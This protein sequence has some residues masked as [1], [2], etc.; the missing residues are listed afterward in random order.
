MKTK[1]TPGPWI[2]GTFPTGASDVRSAD[3]EICLCKSDFEDNQAN[4]RLI[5]AAPDLLEALEFAL[6]DMN[7]CKAHFMKTRDFGVSELALGLVEQAVRKAKGT[8]V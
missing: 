7:R 8:K 6:A 1:H 2:V 5:A 4:A 3:S